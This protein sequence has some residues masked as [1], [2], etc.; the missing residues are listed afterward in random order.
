MKLKLLVLAL[1]ASM[2]MSAFAGF[3]VEPYVGTGTYATSFDVAAAE[4]E[5]VSG[6]SYTTAG[7]RLGYSF[8]LLSAGLDYELMSLDDTTVTN[9][10]L[11]VGVDLP[12]LFRFYGKYIFNSDFDN[13]DVDLDFQSGTVLGVGFTGLPFVVINLEVSSLLYT[14][15]FSGNDVDAAVAA[16]ALTISLPLP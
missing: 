5:E 16:T 15:D 8:S 13:D 9:T 7:G 4:D 6:E 14:F 12:I 1:I 11:F 2:S 10:G 3:M